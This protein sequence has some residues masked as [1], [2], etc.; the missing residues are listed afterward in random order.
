VSQFVSTDSKGVTV[1]GFSSRDDRKTRKGSMEVR[2]RKR[3]RAEE[4]SG[5]A[6]VRSKHHNPC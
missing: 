5:A 6:K 1:T 2:M 3:E 4:L